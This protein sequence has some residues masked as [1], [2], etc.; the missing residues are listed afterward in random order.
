M[1]RAVDGGETAADVQAGA[2]RG[3][4]QAA[5][6]GVQ[7]VVERGDQVARREVVR[8][9]VG[10]GDPAAAAGRRPRRPCV[11]KAAGHVDRVADRHLVPRDTV[12]LHRRQHVTAYRGGQPGRRCGVGLRDRC[13][14]RERSRPEG[15]R[16]GQQA[17]L[18]A[19]EQASVRREHA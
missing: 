2:V 14:Q 13:D 19:L 11:G 9:Q 5:A 7:R 15:Q 3:Y 4:G 18:R 8:E 6:D 10:P 1:G 16:R 17:R 12:D